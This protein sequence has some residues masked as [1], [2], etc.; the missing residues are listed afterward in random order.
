MYE[1]MKKFIMADFHAWK[2]NYFQSLNMEN[3][4][5]ELIMTDF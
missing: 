2:T 3:S 5:K 1:N 4:C